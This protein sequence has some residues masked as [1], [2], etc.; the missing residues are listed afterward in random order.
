MLTPSQLR[1]L[2]LGTGPKRE[3]RDAS[4]QTE[5]NVVQ[6]EDVQQEEVLRKLLRA[7]QTRLRAAEKKAKESEEK[8]KE[9]EE[10]AKDYKGKLAVCTRQ[11]ETVTLE[12]REANTKIKDEQ[13]PSA[14]KENSCVT[15]IIPLH[16]GL[17]FAF[18]GPR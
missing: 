4:S 8:A 10:K 7:S 15:L 13:D 18:Q 3:T 2:F 17:T 6:T 5:A 11:L 16:N 12:L 1:K 9:S 14:G